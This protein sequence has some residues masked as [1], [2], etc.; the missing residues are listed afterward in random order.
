MN[1]ASSAAV[2]GGA[3]AGAGASRARSAASAE[4]TFARRG[5]E[6]RYGS[7]CSYRKAAVYLE[8]L[9]SADLRSKNQIAPSLTR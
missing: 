1:D 9:E 7:T 2:V 5:S 6:F 3:G 8:S 4:L